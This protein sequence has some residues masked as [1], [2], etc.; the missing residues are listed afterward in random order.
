MR[1]GLKRESKT[2]TREWSEYSFNCCLGCAND[3]VYCYAAEREARY[4]RCRRDQ[5]HMEVVNPGK[6]YLARR[7]IKGRREAEG[8]GARGE[9][10]NGKEKLFAVAPIAP[11][12]SLFGPH[13]GVTMFPTGHDI[14]PGNLDACWPVLEA[15]LLCGNRVLLVSKPNLDV[16]TDLLALMMS[17]KSP[18][19]TILDRLEFRFSI[20]GLDEA[21]CQFWEPGASC[22]HD[23][24]EC[25]GMVKFAG[26]K[27]SVSAEPLLEPWRAISIVGCCLG[28]GADHVW[29]GKLNQLRRRTAHANIGGHPTLLKLEAWQDDEHVLQVVESLKDYAAAGKV[30]Y[31]DSYREVIERSKEERS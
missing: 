13:E 6:V 20:G 5:W 31:K 4:K 9:E 26:F 8:R 21:T 16:I 2:G 22:F 23:R 29:I 19:K 18:V 7:I 14:T 25:I 27:V 15:L 17:D 1:P 12:P 3:C 11:R 28:W 24:R 10:R 30:R